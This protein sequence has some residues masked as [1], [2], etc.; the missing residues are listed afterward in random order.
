LGA[1]S[2]LQEAQVRLRLH[3]DEVGDLGDGPVTSVDFGLHAIQP[4][5]PGKA[6]TSA[7]WERSANQRERRHNTLAPWL[8]AEVRRDSPEDDPGLDACKKRTNSIMEA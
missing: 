8:D 5:R 1:I 3:F 2:R 6:P 4:A 7:W